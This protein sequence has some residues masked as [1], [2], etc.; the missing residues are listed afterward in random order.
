MSALRLASGWLVSCA[1]TFALAGT[2]AQARRGAD[3]PAGHVRHC[4]GCDDSP[5]HVRGGRGARG[6][7]ATAEN[8]GRGQSRGRGRERGRGRG[9]DD[10]VVG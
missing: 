6:R 10:D 5:G 1:A 4:R 3:D 7:D 8:R 2:P 9:H